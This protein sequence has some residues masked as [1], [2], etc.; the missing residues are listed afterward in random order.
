MTYLYWDKND[1][2]NLQVIEWVPPQIPMS[3][4]DEGPGPEETAA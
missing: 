1:E 3:D 2:N 4:K